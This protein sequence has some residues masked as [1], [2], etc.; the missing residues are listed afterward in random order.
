MIRRIAPTTTMESHLTGRTIR[1]RLA[2]FRNTGSNKTGI[3]EKDL[4]PTDRPAFRRHSNL[5]TSP[6]SPF[7]KISRPTFLLRMTKEKL[8]LKLLVRQ[9]WLPTTRRHS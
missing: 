9:Y 4:R 5:Q 6:H 2:Y 3:W 7:Y 8:L 1:K